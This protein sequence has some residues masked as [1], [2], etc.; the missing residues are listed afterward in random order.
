[1]PR[2]N[3]GESFA[4]AFLSA[5]QFETERRARKREFDEQMSYRNRELGILSAFKGRGLDIQE[6]QNELYENRSDIMAQPKPLQEARNGEL[7]S[8]Q[9]SPTGDVIYSHK[10]GDIPPPEVKTKVLFEGSRLVN[11][12]TGE[13]LAYNPK[14]S[15]KG[16]PKLEEDIQRTIA[17]IIQPV[18]KT[19]LTGQILGEDVQREQRLADYQLLKQD[20]LSPKGEQWLSNKESG[21]MLNPDSFIR[22]LMSAEEKGE[23]TEAD[24]DVLEALSYSY[25]R[26]YNALNPTK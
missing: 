9:L 16:T 6:V 19:S 4:N 17:R 26:I 7:F 25:P 14:S 13:Q 12:E 24:A 5:Y 20:A 8:T 11:E 2:Q 1:M 3:A 23:I 15:S 21:G 10:V 22:E 18:T